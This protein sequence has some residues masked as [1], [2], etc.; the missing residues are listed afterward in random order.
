MR[1]VRCAIYT[2][3]SSEEGLEQ[4]FNSLDAQREA[5]AAY[6]LS[7]AS[8]GW[9]Q[10]ADLYDDGGLSGGTLQ[11]PALQRLLADV[12]AGRIDI[13]VVYKV[14][15]LTRSLLDFS[16]L[17]EAFDKAGTS[18]VSVTQSFN[19][20]TSMGRLTLN[21]LLS[22]AQFE[23]EVTAERIRD[24]IAA[25]K[26]RGMWMGGTPPLGY[27]PDGRTLA[28]VE[29]HA[30]LVSQIFSRYLELGN[31]RLL[32]ADL[33]ER[34]IRIP[35]RSTSTGKPLGGGWFGRGLL[36]LTLRRVLYTGK[37][38]HKDQVYPGNHPAII[39]DEL[40]AHVQ[41]SLDGHI[42]GNRS[43]VRA[44]SPSLLAGR[45]IDEAG[46]PLLAV[47][48]TKPVRSNAEGVVSRKDDTAATRHRYYVSKALQ[49]RTG[50]SGMRVPAREIETAVINRLAAA[51][52]DPLTL[53]SAAWL[54]V[55]ASGYAELQDRAVA[56]AATVRKRDPG[57]I[58]DL[59]RSIRILP[60]QIEITCDARALATTL[61]AQRATDAPELLVLTAD[62]RLT[63]T[64]HVMR[65]VQES[66]AALTATLDLTIIRLLAKAHAWWRVLRTEPIDVRALAAREGLNKSYV[67]RVLRLA[68]LSPEVVQAIFAGTLKSGVDGAALKAPDA[69]P[70]SWV[71]QRRA[72]LPVPENRAAG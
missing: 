2:R 3:K 26:A 47:H 27:R 54:D 13:I 44:K 35:S 64:G 1:Q 66:G 36:H 29:E 8:E 71:E 41:A 43:K 4:S 57:T 67:S 48:A 39:D 58:R 15:R 25:S 42:Q 6:I 51:L 22:F 19:T 24:K 50:T 5:C 49:E 55:P 59:V 31:V 61:G 21:M 14:D 46:E 56:L 17:V 30:T 12:A 32:E 28:V 23:R 20:T 69:I 18:F 62:A 53:I 9:V 7:Q 72:F 38:P 63:R 65:L 60:Q 10:T 33:R 68:F 16:K 45:I 37:I 70:E 34:G 40:F 11:R 52:D